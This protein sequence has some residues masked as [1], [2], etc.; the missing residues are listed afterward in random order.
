MSTSLGDF[1][2][3]RRQ[4]LGLTQ[5]E[6]AERLGGSVRQSDV[7]R[8]ESNR[9][10]MPRRERLLQIAHALEVSLGELLV[11]SG[12]LTFE[13]SQRLDEVPD[14]VSEDWLL[15]LQRIRE[16]VEALRQALEL[17]SQMLEEAD[18]S[19]ATLTKMAPTMRSEVAMPV[20][21]FDSWETSVMFVD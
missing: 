12:W 4:D 14:A 17:A 5:E 11:S 10:A 16:K 2:R 18:R 8:L 7:S 3:E 15:D 19:L 9:V 1:I 21:I 6:L 13:E 20:G